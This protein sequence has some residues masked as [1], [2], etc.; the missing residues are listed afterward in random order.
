MTSA[1]NITGLIT[2]ELRGP[3]GRLK[4]RLR[5]QNIITNAGR[6]LII[7]RLQ[8][9]TAAVSDYLAIGTGTNAAA[10]GDTS[11]QTELAR[12]QGV[13]SQPDPHTDRCVYTFPAGIGT[14]DITEAGRLNAASS[15]TLVG[16]QVFAAVPKGPDDSLEITY[17]LTY[18][19]S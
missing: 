10:A 8:A 9:G 1:I 3:D 15:G 12:A 4:K 6:Q 7:D 5:L 2:L 16:R 13:L 11:L 18:S 19:A 17:D 14:G